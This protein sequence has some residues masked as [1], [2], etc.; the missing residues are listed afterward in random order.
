MKLKTMDNLSMLGAVVFYRVSLLTYYL[1][2]LIMLY[3]V[4]ILKK[5]NIQEYRSTY[6]EERK[7]NREYA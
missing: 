6:F 2:N 5:S 7:Y 1:T 3:Y 4:S